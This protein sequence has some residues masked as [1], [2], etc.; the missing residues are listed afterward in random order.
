MTAG[1]D[2]K[3]QRRSLDRLCRAA[4]RCRAEIALG[5]SRR[6]SRALILTGAIALLGYL[7]GRFQGIAS[8]PAEHGV[9]IIMSMTVGFLLQ[10]P[11]RCFLPDR[12]WNTLI[13]LRLVEHT[14]ADVT[15][16]HGHLK[17]ANDAAPLTYYEIEALL[18]WCQAE[19][20]RFEAR[21][22]DLAA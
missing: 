12:T 1:T 21:R 8:T 7:I 5:R 6:D 2:A 4:L 22:K 17:R 13:A 19:R 11:L 14:P 9:L 10:Y 15:G 18:A 20:D 16:W 3:A